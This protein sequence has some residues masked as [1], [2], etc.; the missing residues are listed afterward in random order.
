MPGKK[1]RSR[2]ASFLTGQASDYATR[3]W[4]CRSPCQ[5]EPPISYWLSSATASAKA[6]GD[7]QKPGGGK[8]LTYRNRL[9]NM[10][11]VTPKLDM[12]RLIKP[13][14]LT[15]QRDH[16]RAS[17]SGLAISAAAAPGRRATNE[18]IKTPASTATI[19]SVGIN[20]SRRLEALSI[21]RTFTGWRTTRA[22]S[23]PIALLILQIR[24]VKLSGIRIIQKTGQI[25]LLCAEN[26]FLH[27][28]RYPWRPDTDHRS[29]CLL[30]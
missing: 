5:T 19:N 11:D 21:T 7:P 10:G 24:I 26:Q 23:S 17:A 28:Q 20:P 12:K 8:P 13:Q 30:L 27:H 14:L 3:R 29:T 18:Q 2:Q 25:L 22:P 1:C 9:K 4:R 6:A 16:L 15:N